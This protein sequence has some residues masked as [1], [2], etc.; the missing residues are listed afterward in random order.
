MRR[1]LIIIGGGLSIVVIGIAIIFAVLN[2]P[3]LQRTILR[4]SN[5]NASLANGANTG[6]KAAAPAVSPDR[7]EVQYVSRN[8]AE[9]F[10]STSTQNHYGN[11]VESEQ[12]CSKAFSS[13]LDRQVAQ[14]RQSGTAPSS[15]TTVTKA[16]VMKITLLKGTNA[17]VTVSTSRQETTA[18]GTKSFT[19]DLL[20]ELV[21]ENGHWR[22][23]AAAWKPI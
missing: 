6:V 20:L 1:I 23:N 15:Q 10:G 9:V 12:W 16:L 18:S 22:I 14:L 5:I 13:F 19:Q 21:K 8:F 3:G 7:V 4:V 2:N 11:L 17:G